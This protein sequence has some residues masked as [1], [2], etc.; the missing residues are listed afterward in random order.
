MPIG[1][2]EQVRQQ[3]TPRSSDS[4]YR[5]G[6]DI[7]LWVMVI[8]VIIGILGLTEIARGVALIGA[9]TGIIGYPLALIGL[10]MIA[11]ALGL[12][13]FRDW[14]LFLGLLVLGVSAAV[15]GYQALGG[16]DGT[17]TAVVS[18][19]LFFFLLRSEHH[20]Q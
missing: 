13:R 19:V 11:V 2:E 20:F 1:E 12:L 6:V 3:E 16:G 5:S 14:G 18:A 17:I 10:G 9:G 7:P 15:N 8:A 4:G